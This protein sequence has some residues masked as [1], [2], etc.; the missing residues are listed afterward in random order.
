MSKTSSGH[1]PQPAEHLEV[2]VKFLLDD[3][4]TVR[5]SLLQ[6]GAELTHPRVY[7]RNVRYD[8]LTNDLLAKAQLLRLRQDARVRLT[9]K[10]PARL[11]RASEAKVREEIEVTVD[12]FDKLSLILQRI[13]FAPVQMYEKYRETYELGDVEIV[14]DEMPFGLFIELEGPEADI[15]QVAQQLGLDWSRRILVNYLAMMAYFKEIFH[16][17]FDDVTFDNFT[18]HPIS[19]DVIYDYSGPD[20]TN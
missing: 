13:G 6:L 16:L 8:T 17:P 4:E 1:T 2:E 5:A 14:L 20:A 3:F 19:A 10:G 12:D 9:F 7:E 15:K 11:Q 18:T